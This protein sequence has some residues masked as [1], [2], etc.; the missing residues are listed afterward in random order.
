MQ[1]TALVDTVVATRYHNI[2]CALKLGKPTLSIG[3]A[4]KCDVLMADMGLSGFC[5]SVKSFN[6][7]QLIQQ[8]KDLDDRASEVRSMLT[9]RSADRRA[10][11]GDQFAE[12]S[13]AL[14]LTPEEAGPSPFLRPV[15]TSVS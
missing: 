7:A 13:D 6:V 1:Q 5:Q 9:G 15:Q 2:V 11:V 10:M 3:Y 4:E 8:F 12:L 14:V